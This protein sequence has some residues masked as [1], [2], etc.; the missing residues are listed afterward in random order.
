MASKLKFRNGDIHRKSRSPSKEESAFDVSNQD[1]KGYISRDWAFLKTLD[2][3]CRTNTPSSEISGLVRRHFAFL[4]ATFLAPLDR[5]F[6]QLITPSSSI[7][8][9]EYGRFSETDFLHSLSKHGSE[10]E[11]KGKTHFQ[12]NKVQETFYK[13]FCRSPSFFSWLRMKME[14][15]KQGQRSVSR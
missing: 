2:E 7:D 9:F 5:Y 4:T 14:Q 1:C 12:R 15:A 10:V 8:P 6:A 11:F 3:A 13:K